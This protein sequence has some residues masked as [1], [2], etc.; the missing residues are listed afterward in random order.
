MA[1]QGEPMSTL[2]R[3]VVAS[4]LLAVL[5]SCLDTAIPQP[6]AQLPGT[7]RATLVT[8]VA[9]RDGFVPAKGAVVRLA[10]TT[11]EAT[12]D[13]EGAVVLT[14]LRA[15]TGRLL[16]SYDV[17]GNG[18][19]DRTRTMQ[20]E[21]LAAGFGRDVNLGQ[22]VLGRNATVV[23]F[24]RRGDGRPLT[25]GHGGI[26][27]FLPQL[28]QLTWTADDGSFA[29]PAVPEGPLVV[30][31][32][33]PG[34]RDESTSADVSAG[35]EFRLAPM[36]LSP[37]SPGPLSLVGR[38]ESPEGAPLADVTVRAAAAGTEREVRT[39]AEGR[40]SLE[41]LAPGVYSMALW[42]A[43]R[44]PLFV[45]NVGVAAGRNDLG[46]LVMEAGG[47][48]ALP[49]DGGPS[50][51]DAGPAGSDGG[52]AGGAAGG[53]GGSGG[54]VAGGS[55]GGMAG[56]PGGGMAGGPGGGMAGGSG[57]GMAGG[58]GGGM[59]GGS[60]GGMA[61]GSG[62]GMAGGSGGGVA[63]PVAVVGPPQIV[64]PGAVAR[65]DGAGSMGITPLRYRWTQRAGPTVT[66]SD[67]DS[68]SAD[69]PS[70]TAPATPARL[71]FVLTV[72]EPNSGLSSTNQPVAVVSVSS[73]PIARFTPDG[74]LVAG[75]QTVTLQSTSFDDGGLP[76]VQYDW[77]SSGFV[78][79][80]QVDGGTAWL[81]LQPLAF[82]A[83]DEL[84][85]VEL[86]VTNSVGARS[87]PFRRTFQVRGS[88]PN[89]WSLDAG[90]GQSVQVGPV[91]PTLSF[92]GSVTPVTATPAV[93]W[94]CAPPLPLLNATTLTPQVVAPTIV[95]A[96]RVF[97]CTMT[98]MGLP[99]LNPPLLTATTNVTLFDAAPPE[100]R[101][102]SFT[103]ARLNPF[104]W[105]ARFSE[106]I[107]PQFSGPMNLGGGCT[108]FITYNPRLVPIIGT[109]AGLVVPRDRL[110]IGSTC[111]GF[112]VDIADRATTRNVTM[113]VS[114]GPSSPTPVQA[115]WVGPWVSAADYADPRP[116]IASMGPLPFDELARW[117]PP[118]PAPAP[119]ELLGREGTSLLRAPGFDPLV[120]DA[121]CGP[122]CSLTFQAQPLAGL[123]PSGAAF[124]GTR[125][126]YG[127]GS[128]FVVMESPPDGGVAG[129]VVTERTPSGVWQAGVVLGGTPLQ[130]AD[131]F[132]QLRVDGGVT[133]LDNFT[134]G[135]FV[136]YE[137]VADAGEVF[138]GTLARADDDHVA[139]AVGPT[140]TLRAYSR[141]APFTWVP[142]STSFSDVVRVSGTG[143]ASPNCAG[144]PDDLPIAVVERATNPKLSL[145]R[146]DRFPTPATLVSSQTLQGWA[147]VAR[148]G[149]M[150][151]AVSI[152]G[153]VRLLVSNSVGST[154]ASDFNGPPRVGFPS[155]P[156]AL[157]LDVFCEAAWPHLAFIEDALVVTWQERCAPQ[158]R[159]RIV[160]RVIR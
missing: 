116:V 139:I 15:R 114:L 19:P 23:G 37:V 96:P 38:V 45:P 153:D 49:L 84:A 51:P 75:G 55:G 105:V 62:G 32:L 125:S 137:T 155:P 141:S 63:L 160:T 123:T 69:D 95:G 85:S 16:F 99:P 22:V 50:A 87:A 44:R 94:S 52:M 102:V 120:S 143:V 135:T 72:T 78:Q 31:A 86:Q 7:I 103:G 98:A 34:F 56:G 83:P 146:L 47:G 71:E 91:P 81:T 142:T 127:R 80:L 43:D 59:A 12:A 89:N 100:L 27:V 76:L 151:V 77:A 13:D 133:Y 54:G 35:A 10:G 17:D 46:V 2:R 58:S 110:G 148:G 30:T 11:L 124:D 147:A 136:P 126:F 53:S 1:R 36:V 134:A 25:T 117:S 29:L 82:M 128:L 145:V 158:T 122:S 9:H 154:G 159:W 93:S 92:R 112:I 144:C 101:S 157:D 57:G 109:S 130:V 73:V 33:A 115:E 21:Q 65:L 79:S 107:Q 131:T 8:A 132:Q 121:G 108:P 14:G 60:G 39:D 106:P 118:S 67:N 140:R 74:G 20:L 113:N 28:P 70:F 138:T 48:V 41:A 150:V 149:L 97:A 88:N 6:V 104:G 152:D 119:F 26:A 66:L 111:A 61:G 40:F 68:L 90:P 24:A 3:R 5:P 129:A 42:R 64:A 4:L 156:P 18:T